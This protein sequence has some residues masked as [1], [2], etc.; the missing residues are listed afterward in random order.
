VEK[1]CGQL[2]CEHSQAQPTRPDRP[3]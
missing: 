2:G 1:L 3:S